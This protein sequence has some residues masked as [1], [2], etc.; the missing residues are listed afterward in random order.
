MTILRYQ[1][2]CSLIPLN[3]ARLPAFTRGNKSDCLESSPASL[4]SPIDQPVNRS[5]IFK[6]EIRY[7]RRMRHVAYV[8]PCSR[9]EWTRD[10]DSIHGYIHRLW[11]CNSLRR[12]IYIHFW[13]VKE[14]NPLTFDLHPRSVAKKKQIPGPLGIGN[15]HPKRWLPDNLI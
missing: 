15:H 13:Q 7:D 2:L 6:P 1:C 14:S 9:S 4:Q 11:I 12:S 5:P 8:P 10:G 3:L